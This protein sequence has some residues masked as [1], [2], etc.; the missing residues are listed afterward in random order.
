MTARIRRIL[1]PDD[2]ARSPYL[3]LP[4]EVRSGTES[5][6]VRLTYDRSAGVV[7]LG[8]AGAASFRGWS[9]GARSRFVIA[10]DAATPG[11]LPGPLEDGDWAVVLGLHRIPAPGLDVLVEIDQP[12]SGPPESEPSPPPPPSPSDRRPR[13]ALPAPDGLTWLACDF[14]AHT[15]H[16]D[17]S[18]GIAGLAARA[19]DAGLDVLAVTD[20]N[21][22]S[23]HP[24]LPE[25]AAR[26]GVVLVPGQELTTDRGHA[27]A[28]GDIG[29]IDFRK[30]PSIWV[31]VVTGRGGLLSINHPLASDCSWH[32]PLAERPPLAEIWHW[33]WLDRTWTGP[34]SWWA[35]WGLDTVP[36]G[37][38][39]FHRPDQDRPVGA[40]VTWVAA[41]SAKPGAVLDGLRTGRTAVAASADAPVLLRVNDELVAVDADGTLLVDTDGRRRRVHGDFARFP[42]DPGPHR[43]ETPLACVVAITA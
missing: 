24:H 38:S 7:D 11:Y 15:V 37:G 43:L 17:G 33:T 13:R 20:H 18:L 21:T 30:P 29:W 19:V 26:Y 12:A 32:H 41:E 40:P 27:N 39:D 16:S 3:E 5:I 8:C 28:F 35:A 1:T 23:H 14:H 4:F 36:V 42:A 22:V 6:E 25:I 34:L 2:R 31:T 9:G 10:G